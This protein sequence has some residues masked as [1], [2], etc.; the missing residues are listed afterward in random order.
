MPGREGITQGR[1][2]FCILEVCSAGFAYQSSFPD[3]QL[4]I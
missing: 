1:E 2:D 4:R 3:A